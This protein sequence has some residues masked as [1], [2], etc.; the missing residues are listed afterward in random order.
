MQ[1]LV[2]SLGPADHLWLSV[3]KGHPELRLKSSDAARAFL[4]ERGFPERII[5]V[6]LAEHVQAEV[7]ET[8]AK[9]G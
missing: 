6:F 8:P 5:S 7:P 3:L 9:P 4:E 2:W 1:D